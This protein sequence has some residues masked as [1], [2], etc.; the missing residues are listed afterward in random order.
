MSWNIAAGALNAVAPNPVTNREFTHALAAAVGR[1][2]LFPVPALA[3]RLL[4]GEGAYVITEG[5]RVLPDATRSA[6]YTF[7]HPTL[8]EA[9][10]SLLN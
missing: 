3:A 9:L 4:F 2:A 7:R 8:D 6:G 10:R 5:Q 1:P